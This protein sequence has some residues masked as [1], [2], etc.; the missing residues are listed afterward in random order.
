MGDMSHAAAHTAPVSG[1]ETPP[2]P[3][4]RRLEVRLAGDRADVRAA[5]ALRYRVFCREMGARPTGAAVEPGYE[6][7]AF[8]AHCDHLLVIDHAR[9]A[10]RAVVGT[11]RLMPGDRAGAAGGFYS[12]REFDLTPLLNDGPAA[13]R[14]VEV[15]RSCVAEGYRTN[16]TVQLLWRGIAGYMADHDVEALFGC[17]SFPTTDTVG[18]ATSLAYLHQSHLAPLGQ[19]VRPQP[20]RGVAMNGLGL[21]DNDRAATYRALPPLIKGYLRLGAVVGDGA[22]IDHEFATTDVF[23]HLRVNKI[24]ARYFVH[25]RA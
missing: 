13:A 11:Y 9:P 5:Q 18:L 10:D 22:V 24:P 14:M 7:D 20:G 23:M 4:P 12:A 1:F 17:A 16:A 2:Q 6:A 19:R 21:S 8:D 3:L 15:G 25:F